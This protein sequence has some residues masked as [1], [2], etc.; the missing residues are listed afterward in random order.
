MYKSEEFKTLKYLDFTSVAS[1]T[2]FAFYKIGQ[3]LSEYKSQIKFDDFKIR[4]CPFVSIWSLHYL[5][6][7]HDQTLFDLENDH[8]N[9]ENKKK[10]YSLFI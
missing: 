6:K 3:A 4:D 7:I 8:V 9:L 10:T 2:D 1:A 5:K